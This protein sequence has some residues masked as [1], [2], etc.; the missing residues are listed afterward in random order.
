[1]STSRSPCT[2]SGTGPLDRLCT[3][4][5]S[6][7]RPL[8]HRRTAGVHRASRRTSARRL[9][10]RPGR[11]TG[12]LRSL[13]GGLPAPPRPPAGAHSPFLR[14][15][16]R[17]RCRGR[18][19]SVRV[20]AAHGAVTRAGGGGSLAEGPHSVLRP[21]LAG[22]VVGLVRRRDR[23]LGTPSVPTR[24]CSAMPSAAVSNPFRARGAR[25]ERI[26][27]PSFQLRDLRHE[28]GSRFE[29]AGIPIIYV[30]KLL[31]HT[32]LTTT[33]RYTSTAGSCIA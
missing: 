5:R 24:S 18:Q 25:R 23:P 29:E 27:L 15:L 22:G 6:A 26:G 14:G 31:G 33:S 21:P 20:V 2:R 7:A 1:M 8:L 17:V 3:P 28:A 13:S 19:G 4:G 12:R 30:S 11:H 9:R 10:A 16:R 32:N